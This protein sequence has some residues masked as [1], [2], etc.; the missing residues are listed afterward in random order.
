MA[1]RA[2]SVF[3]ALAL[4]GGSVFAVLVA[5]ATN[6]LACENRGTP[7]CARKDNS[8]D[9]ASVPPALSWFVSRYGRQTRAA[10]LHDHL[11]DRTDVTD[12]SADRIVRTALR[13]SEVPFLRRWIMWTAVS[14]ASM[15]RTR[16]GLAGLALY[17][18]QLIAFF[19]SLVYWAFARYAW[20]PFEWLWSPLGGGRWWP[21]EGRFWPA[22]NGVPFGG[23]P[24]LLPLVLALLGLVWGLKWLFGVLGVALIALPAFFVYLTYFVVYC[25][26]WLLTGPCWVYYKAKRLDIRIPRPSFG[27]PF[28]HEAGP[29]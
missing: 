15:G 1:R 17:G 23:R 25:L 22:D 21:I 3:V 10:L 13:D 2:V 27:E 14:L 18:L 28:R 8:T 9:L 19:A 4:L 5:W 7:A 26:D 29:F 6:W 20:W 11:I 16:W 12:E 24:W